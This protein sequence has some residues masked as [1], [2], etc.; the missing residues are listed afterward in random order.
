MILFPILI[1]AIII[2]GIIVG[3]LSLIYYLYYKKSENYIK[4]NPSNG[5]Y[6][7]KAAIILNYFSRID[8]LTMYGSGI[9]ILMKL[10]KLKNKS[11]EYFENISEEKF[12]EI[13]E[14][15]N[16]DTIFVF[17]HGTYGSFKISSTNV[18]AYSKL[19]G[20]SEKDFI[21]QLHCCKKQKNEKSLV[22]IIRPK[23]S[24]IEEK[25]RWNI[26]NLILIYGWLLKKD[27][28]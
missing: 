25:L 18:I 11:Y 9:M 23:H 26:G 6:G 7:K 12:K 19:N 15:A 21:A 20:F 16:I 4:L 17:G 5:S 1:G 14:D 10:L 22:D 3:L 8:K 28:K 13:I 27:W 24:F 2:L